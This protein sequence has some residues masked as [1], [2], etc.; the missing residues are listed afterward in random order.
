M[1]SKFGTISYIFDFIL[2]DFLRL[3]IALTAA[4]GASNFV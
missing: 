2:K 4:F 3:P 1:I